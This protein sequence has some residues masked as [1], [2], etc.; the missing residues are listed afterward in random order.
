MR[1][2]FINNSSAGA[3]GVR[4]YGALMIAALRR[5]GVEVI[6]WD[7]SYSAIQARGGQYLPPDRSTYDLVHFNWHP[8]AINHYIPEHFAGGPPLSLY[9]GDVPPHSSCPVFNIATW[10]FAID[11]CAGAQ[12]LPT[13]IPP[14]PLDLPPPTL[15][16]VTIGVSGVRGAGFALTRAICEEKGWVI[17]QHSDMWLSTEDEIRRLASCTVNVCW[18]QTT[19]R[20]KSMAAMFCIAA[21]RPLVISSSTMFSALWPYKDEIYSPRNGLDTLDLL[22]SVAVEHT[23]SGGAPIPHRAR[24]ELAWDVVIKT[25]VKQWETP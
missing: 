11:P 3:C 9:L 19:G 17:N 23:Q 22:L 18:Y 10:R 1:I 7:G 2:L 12:Y 6:E 4:E 8:G 21:Q 5:A 20:G 25:V 15:T 16:P 24:R 13:P 14:T